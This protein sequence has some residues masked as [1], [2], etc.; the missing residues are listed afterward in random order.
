MERLAGKI[1]IVAGGASGIGA[2]TAERLASEGASVMIAD[3]NI[4]Q[5]RTTAAR[6]EAAGG[7]AAP[8]H[9]DIADESSVAAQL[10]KDGIPSGEIAISAKGKRDL[11]VPTADGVKEPQ[12][13]RVQIVYDGGPT[14]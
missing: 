6:I 9:C 4:D 7:K 10:Q 8:I 14:S 2:A 13:R 1:V 3:V 11:L 12:N 5:A